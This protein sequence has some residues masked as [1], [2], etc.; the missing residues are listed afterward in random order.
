MPASVTS[1]LDLSAMQEPTR[2]AW[3]ERPVLIYGPR[4]S[5]TTLLLNL[6]DGGPDLFVFPGELKLKF[7]LAEFFN[8]GNLPRRYYDKSEILGKTFPGFDSRK[9]SMLSGRASAM[10]ARSLRDLLCVDACNVYASLEDKPEPPALWGMKEV[11]GPT[12]QVL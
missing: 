4:K 12:S 8:S 1:G 3:L 2:P 11:G 6:L 7:L 5:G 10:P 9:Y